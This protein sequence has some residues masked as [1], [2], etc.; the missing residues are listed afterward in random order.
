MTKEYNEILIKG[1]SQLKELEFADI[2]DEE[3]IEHSFS[4]KYIKEKNKL[5]K[6]LGHSYWKLVNTV[7][8]KAAIII[9]TLIIAFSSLMT[10][11]AVR[12]KFMDFVFKI[13]STFTEIEPKAATDTV[14][15]ETCYAIPEPPENYKKTYV[16]YN[17]ATFFMVWTND[18]QQDIVLTQ[19]LTFTMH[20]F[21]SEE[22]DLNEKII[23]DTACLTCENNLNYFCFWEFDGYRFELVYPKEL[24]EG[25]MTDVVGNLVEVEPENNIN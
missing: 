5:I 19:E 23:N 20:V 7:A 6:Q 8:K 14:C 13:Y 9:I 2:P 21:N 1:L 15:I 25:F 3:Q 16:N 12:E 24:G 18:N 4:E 17:E 22:G 10:V 11:D